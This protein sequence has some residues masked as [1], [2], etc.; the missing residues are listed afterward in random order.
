MHCDPATRGIGLLSVAEAADR[1][2]S[3][4]TEYAIC[5]PAVV[6]KA[7]ALS[8]PCKSIFRAC[9]RTWPLCLRRKWWSLKMGHAL[10]SDVNSNSSSR[11]H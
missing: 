3:S 5:P 9:E 4:S 8:A 6:T 11:Q 10:A 1:W 2:F 7:A